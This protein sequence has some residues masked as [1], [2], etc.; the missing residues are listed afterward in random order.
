M[1]AEV[2]QEDFT[3]GV[4]L[5]DRDRYHTIDERNGDFVCVRF[6]DGQKAEMASPKVESTTNDSKQ[7][8]ANFSLRTRRKST[9]RSEVNKFSSASKMSK[10]SINSFRHLSPT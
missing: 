3:L 5:A 7:K 1:Q 10:L 9:A 8:S 4:N 6:P 2:L